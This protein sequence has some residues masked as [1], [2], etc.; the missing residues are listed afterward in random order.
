MFQDLF[1]HSIETGSLADLRRGSN[2]LNWD[3]DECSLTG[4]IIQ[5]LYN[6]MG[7]G[8]FC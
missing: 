2:S 4:E 7:M 6:E 5:G 8:L 1:R 3:T